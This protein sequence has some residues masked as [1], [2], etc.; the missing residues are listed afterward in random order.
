MVIIP[1]NG[2]GDVYRANW[3][4]W[5]HRKINKTLNVECRLENMPD[6]VIARESIWLP[7][8]HDELECDEY[9]IAVGHRSVIAML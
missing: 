7:F 6:P 9:T 8:M 4:G 1:G 2:G 5:L 3:Y